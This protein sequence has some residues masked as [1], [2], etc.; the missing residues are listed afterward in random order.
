ML[1]TLVATASVPETPPGPRPLIVDLVRA[2]E[3]ILLGLVVVII[4]GILAGGGFGVL[5]FAAVLVLPPVLML[6]F[7]HQGAPPRRLF[8]RRALG[9]LVGW[10]LIWVVFIPL[11]IFL[12]YAVILG[13]EQPV[14]FVVL[15]ILDGIILGLSMAA[16]DRLARWLGRHRPRVQETS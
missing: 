6:F 16:V 5:D 14:V 1:R 11:F 7:M 8:L 10:A 13:S 3:G 15:A 4:A 12:A 9:A 2:Y